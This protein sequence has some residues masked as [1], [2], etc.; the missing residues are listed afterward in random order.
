MN[1]LFCYKGTS[2]DVSLFE[3]CSRGTCDYEVPK[4]EWD[5]KFKKM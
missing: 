4:E 5:K 3:D 1:K 2:M